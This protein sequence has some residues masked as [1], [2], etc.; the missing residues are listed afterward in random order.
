[1]DVALL[2]SP[3]LGRAG[4]AA[5]HAVLHHVVVDALEVRGRIAI[6]IG[7]DLL[8]H[9]VAGADHILVEIG[10]EAQL[11]LHVGGGGE[12][13]ALAVPAH[14]GADGRIDDVRARLG[15]LAAGRDEQAVGVVAMVVQH[16]IG[17]L[18]AQGRDELAH[19]VRRA[20]SGHVLEA[21]DDHLLGLPGA[22]TGH[23]A[24]QAQDLLGDVE[25]MLHGE[26]LGPG[27]GQRGLEDV[28]RAGQGHLG[29]GPHVVDM[30][31]EVEAADDVVMLVDHLA[32]LAHEIGG[33]GL[34]AQD[35]GGADEDLLQRLGGQL[36]PL[37]RLGERIGHVGQHGHVEVRPAAVLQREE[38]AVV[39]ILGDEGILG[40][41]EAVAAVGLR[42][43]ASGRVHEMDR[44]PSRGCSPGSPGGRSEDRDNRRSWGTRAAAR[45]RR[46]PCAC[47]GGPGTRPGRHIRCSPWPRCRR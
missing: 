26:A 9:E 14:A 33:L 20:D 43:V 17:I 2:Q 25:V 39:E 15:G 27:H 12:H 32:G 45:A 8:E 6:V 35:V 42:D 29:E 3:F 37:G 1:M 18:L 31:Q 22:H 21:Q 47:R 44:G 10:L 23:V 7:H 5:G 30:V 34:V 28:A 46:R 16:E 4:G 19:E 36:V 38:P 40:Q 41:A 24:H 11:L 13:L